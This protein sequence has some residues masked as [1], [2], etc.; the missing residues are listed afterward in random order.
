MLSVQREV[1]MMDE[2]V[3]QYKDMLGNFD[4]QNDEID[5]DNLF[6]LQPEKDS[7]VFHGV[8]FD[9]LEEET[10]QNDAEIKKNII[11]HKIRS[12]IKSEWGIDC[13]A[14]F[15]HVFRWTAGPKVNGVE[16]ILV[17]FEDK[18]DKEQIWM[19]LSLKLRDDMLERRDSVMVTQVG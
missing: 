14:T 7:L 17:V 4:P 9:K 10:Q 13:K 8:A 15:K 12:L 11:E 1:N 5:G 3:G 19:K 16:P 6:D 18:Q 2:T